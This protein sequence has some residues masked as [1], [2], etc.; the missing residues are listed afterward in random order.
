MKSSTFDPNNVI[1]F[2]TEDNSAE[3]AT[4]KT[5]AGGFDRR[6]TQIA[7]I[8]GNGETFHTRGDIELF[9]NWLENRHEQYVYAHNLQYDIGNLFSKQLDELDY[10]LVGGRLIKANWRGKEFRDTFNIY[11]LALKKIGQAVGLDKLEMDVHS[12]EYV[13]RDVEILKRAMEKIFEY[14]KK[15]K[16]DRVPSTLGGLAVRTYRSMGLKNWH[17][18]SDF[19]RDALYGGRVELFDKGG[20]GN[21]MYVDVNSL[22]PHCMTFMYPKNNLKIMNDVEGW[23]VAEVLLDVPECAI[24]PLPVRNEHGAVYYPYGKIRGTYTF[25]E[26]RNAV[27]HGAQLVKVYRADGTLEAESY[28]EH[29]VRALYRMRRESTSE[30]DK[31]MYKLLMNN[32]YGRLTIKGTVTRTLELTEERYKSKGTIFGN[33]ILMDIN[34]PVPDEANYMHGAYVT[35]YGRILLYRFM[36]QVGS[37]NLIYCD[38]DSIFFYWNKDR[39]LPFTVGENLGEMKIEAHAAEC[40]TYAPKMYQ[41]DTEYKAKGIPKAKAKTFIESGEVAFEQPFKLRESITYMSRVNVEK[42]KMFKRELS[43]WRRVVKKKVTNYDKKILKK[44]KFFPKFVDLGKKI[45]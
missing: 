19:H 28:Y 33:K 37:E 31:L 14:C 26:I 43:V 20:K 24:A 12:Q 16:I 15:M 21:I 1:Y 27:E 2:D 18:S 13:F 8:C 11:P 35:S 5:K 3:L 4:S 7:A 6:V 30:A 39:P 42:S 22:Y 32:L 29:Y 36:Q 9:K 10:V 45:Y 25:H 40:Y 38:T 17:S 34:T 44:N 23:G 41:I